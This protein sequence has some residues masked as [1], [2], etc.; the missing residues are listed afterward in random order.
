MLI[1]ILTVILIYSR[2]VWGYISSRLPQSKLLSKLS[3]GLLTAWNTAL[4]YRS[5]SL[6]LLQDYTCGLY[7]PS[8]SFRRGIFGS[9]SMLKLDRG[10][11][12]EESWG[13]HANIEENEHPRN[14]VPFASRLV[15]DSLASIAEKIYSRV[16]FMQEESARKSISIEVVETTEYSEK[17]NLSGLWQWENDEAESAFFLTTNERKTLLTMSA[18]H[19]SKVTGKEATK[20]QLLQLQRSPSFVHS[21]RIILERAH[22]VCRD[23]HTDY[24]AQVTIVGD[25]LVVGFRGTANLR[26][27]AIDLR[28]DPA[29]GPYGVRVHRGFLDVLKVTLFH[30]P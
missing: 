24:A 16:S 23:A 30:I 21:L 29:E 10:V 4:S 19:D 12:H 17:V 7:S 15:K 18:E 8:R 28:I 22:W 11:S 13:F 3:T 1:R 14:S 2:A 6:A 20:W 25:D 26:D 9:P 27:L 5:V